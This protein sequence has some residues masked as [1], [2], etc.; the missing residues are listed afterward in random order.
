MG[1][2]VNI[3]K[4]LGD[5]GMES[6]YYVLYVSEGWTCFIIFEVVEI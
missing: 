1:H 2:N 6:F 5:K 3:W 4:K